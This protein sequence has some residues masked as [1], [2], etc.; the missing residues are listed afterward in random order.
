[1]TNDVLLIVLNTKKEQS[2][3]AQSL[4]EEKA[5]EIDRKLETAL[6]GAI[7]ALSCRKIVLH[8][9]EN[10]ADTMWSKENLI[11]KQQTEK[12]I[13]DKL[14]S[15]FA[16][17]IIQDRDDVNKVV[18]VAADCPQLTQQIIEKA[19]ESLNKYD[20][21]I[22]PEKKGSYYL[23][24]MKEPLP[25]LFDSKLWSGKHLLDDTLEE[26]IEHGKNY[27]LLPELQRV[28]DIYDLHLVK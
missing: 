4:G 7:A 10:G 19:F 11:L 16:D 5:Q 1:M 24:G 12:H 15:A 28:N 27:F 17:Y 26:L 18:F 20:V 3:L 21:C 23:I 13:N 8:S 14:K 9:D 6:C 22:G 25:F 2:K